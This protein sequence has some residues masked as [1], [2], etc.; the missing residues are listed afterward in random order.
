MAEADVGQLREGQ[1][2][3]LAALAAVPPAQVAR[4]PSEDSWNAWEIAY[5]LFDIERWYVAKLCEAA[6]PDR[7]A[8][9]GRFMHVWSRLRDEAIEL[10]RAIPVERLEQAGLLG[11]VADWTP[12]VLIAAIAAHDREHAAQVLAARGLTG[13]AGAIDESAGTSGR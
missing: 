2:A 8:A 6:A 3:V 12:R 11:G 5:H 1:A 10:A 13:S 9:L 4:R 7:S